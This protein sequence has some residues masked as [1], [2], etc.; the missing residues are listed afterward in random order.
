MTTFQ[1]LNDDWNADPNGP[2][3]T[4]VVDEPDVVVSFRMNP[5]IFPQFTGEDIG[6]LQF[7]LCSRYRLGRTNDEGFYRGQCRFSKLA[8]RWGEF[9]EVG[10]DLRLAESPDDWVE[11]SPTSGTSCHFLFYFRDDT[12]ECDATDWILEVWRPDISL[13]PS[14]ADADSSATADRI[15]FRR[16]SA[17]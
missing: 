9:Y 7:Y 11:L 16:G 10:G 2:N 13:Q 6:R 3:P 15:I 1:Q 8:P 12:F 14:T 5:L 17:R 4:V